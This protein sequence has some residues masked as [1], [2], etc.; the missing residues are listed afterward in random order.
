LEQQVEKLSRASISANITKEVV[1]DLNESTTTSRDGANDSPTLSEL[2]EEE[3][4]A[5][6]K[7]TR[8][9]EVADVTGDADDECPS[10]LRWKKGEAIGEGTF[11]KVFKGLNEKT[12]EL[13]AIKQIPLT[14]GS[15][16]DADELRREI[17]VMWDLDHPNIVRLVSSSYLVG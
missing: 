7:L 2:S 13:L 11:G 9:D 5:I 8:L 15:Q 10:P 4:Q 3:G 14:D 16:A 1:A 12:G 6:G 17:N